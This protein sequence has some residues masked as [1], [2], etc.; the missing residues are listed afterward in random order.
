MPIT[1][2]QFA[3]GAAGLALLAKE[4]SLAMPSPIPAL[5]GSRFLTFN[6]VIRVNQIEVTRTHNVGADESA[7]HTPERVR[8]MR[9]A[10]ERGMPGGRMTWAFSWLALQDAR[11]NYRAIREIVAEYCHRFGDEV[12]FIPG[13]YFA[14]MYNARAQVNA[15]MHEALAMVSSM[16]G[17]GYRPRSVVAGFLAADNLRYLAER[18]KIHVA[19]GNIWSQYGIDN[20]DG[21]G[22]PSYPYYPSREHFLKPAQGKA[23]F[24]DCVNLD[25][26]TCD[27]LAARR[28]GFEEGFNSRMGVGPIET[29]GAYGP[30]VGLRQMVAT[31]AAH[32]D[33]GFGLNG[34]AWVTNCWEVSLAD[35][36]PIENLAR[37]LSAV[38]TRWP[39]TKC[40]TQGEFGLA[41]R[42]RFRDNAKWSYRFVQRGTGIGGSDADREIRWFMN[43]SFRLALLR[44]LGPGGAEVVI[45]LTRYDLP[46]REPADARPDAPTRNWSL[47][48]RIN[49][50]RTRPQDKPVPLA[51]L[52]AEDR[53]LIARHYPELLR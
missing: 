39:E 31:T 26:W 16:V 24:I 19:Q 38:R 28:A 48:N 20:G 29:V 2:R 4:R 41:W 30:E 11:P 6:T 35:T 49:Q 33:A 1:R 14:P 13:A 15:D 21:D 42:K 23:D 37:W 44:D 10:F 25:G 52:P 17:G 36:I 18:E 9:D 53:E 3:A 51:D 43:R 47:M 50:K 5:M 40:V 7:S 34:F 22:A 32:F 12:T 27:F 8:A 45:D 46:A